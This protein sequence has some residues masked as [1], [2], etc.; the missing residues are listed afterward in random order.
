MSQFMMGNPMGQG[1]MNN[2]MGQ[3]MRPQMFPP[4]MMSGNFM[5]N[6]NMMPM[7]QFGGGAFNQQNRFKRQNPPM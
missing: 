1:M 4:Q 6:R 7:Q 2:P 3:G 5:M